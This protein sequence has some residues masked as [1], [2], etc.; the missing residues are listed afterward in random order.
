VYQKYC[1]KI[2]AKSREKKRGEKHLSR[3]LSRNIQVV[4]DA[5]EV[6]NAY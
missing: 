2:Y 4:V 3:G 6:S 1:V 5:M